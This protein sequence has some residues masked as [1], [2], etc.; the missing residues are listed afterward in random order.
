MA[1]ISAFGQDHFAGVG[2]AAGAAGIANTVVHG[3]LSGHLQGGSPGEP[4][5]ASTRQCFRVTAGANVGG[6][7]GRFARLA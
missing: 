3:F 4:T 1:L 5:F 7:V 6:Q 2:Q